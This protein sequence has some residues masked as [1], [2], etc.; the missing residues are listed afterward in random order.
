[1]HARIDLAAALPHRSPMLFIDDVV[2][3]VPAREATAER[4]LRPSDVW[5]SDDDPDAAGAVFP[6]MLVIEALAQT[7]CVLATQGLDG[8]GARRVP[9]LTGVDA[10]RFASPARVGERLRLHVRCTRTWGPFWRLEAHAA[11]GER[12]VAEARLLATMTDELPRRR[13]TTEDQR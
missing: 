1:M 6:D 9:L 4:T 12:L 5:R 10:A 13:T 11:V 3:L 2:G 7:A 8:G